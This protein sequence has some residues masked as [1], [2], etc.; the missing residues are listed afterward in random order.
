[1]MRFLRVQIH[2]IS[3]LVEKVNF[4]R[5]DQLGVLIQWSVLV[6][7]GHFKWL[8]CPGEAEM[9][10]S[11]SWDLSQVLD[12]VL[13][14]AGAISFLIIFLNFGRIHLDYRFAS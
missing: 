5:I 11:S 14:A 2:R 13:T 7:K 3:K 10:M 8:T 1:M 6:T 9:Q 4:D 12:S